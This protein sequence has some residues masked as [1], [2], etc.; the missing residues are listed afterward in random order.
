MATLDMDDHPQTDGH[1]LTAILAK[2]EVKGGPEWDEG[3]Q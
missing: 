3:S 2:M 1:T